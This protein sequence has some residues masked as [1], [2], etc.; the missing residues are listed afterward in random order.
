MIEALY[1]DQT[2]YSS[3]DYSMEDARK[4]AVTMAS[5]ALRRRAQQDLPVVVAA[6]TGFATELPEGRVYSHRLTA[7]QVAHV[8]LA[9]GTGTS[10]EVASRLGVES[11]Q[12]RH[13][14]SGTRY[15]DVPEA[16]YGDT[17]D[18]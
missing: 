8:R 2:L 15:S 6:L 17:L 16:L 1:K 5:V 10:G 3:T 12:V 7:E 13:V 14:W 9:R 18:L 11:R 4:A